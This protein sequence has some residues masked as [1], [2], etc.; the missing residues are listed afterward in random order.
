M[1]ETYDVCAQL[2]D[3]I[4]QFDD[5]MEKK[6]IDFEADME[7]EAYICAD[8]GLMELVWNNLMSN[9]LKFTQDGGKIRLLQKEL[10]I[11][12]RYQ[13]RTMDAAWIVK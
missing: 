7:D 12:S 4:I 5:S 3:C 8:P 9:A 10:R 2:C 6:N 11:I 1:P 13:Y